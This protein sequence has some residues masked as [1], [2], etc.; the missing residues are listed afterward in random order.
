MRQIPPQGYSQQQGF[1]G[2]PRQMYQA[3]GAGM[4][5]SGSMYSQ[6]GMPMSTQNF[7]AM[8][9][10]IYGGSFGGNPMAASGSM[11]AGSNMNVGLPPSSASAA[12]K[13][14]NTPREEW[15]S[16]QTPRSQMILTEGHASAYEL[17]HQQRVRLML[18]ER[19]KHGLTL[20]SAP[21]PGQAMLTKELE[22]NKERQKRQ[23]IMQKGWKSAV[24]A[25]MLSNSVRV[26]WKILES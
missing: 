11:Q 20:S 26:L 21:S 19:E 17:F 5:F 16:S 4:G 13:M 12:A 2:P 10:G 6:P 9:A 25:M 23:A 24:E 7:N 18:Q 8:Q 14:L 1:G 22:A 3:A 15:G